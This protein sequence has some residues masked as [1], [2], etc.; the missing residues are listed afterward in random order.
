MYETI[1]PAKHTNDKKS[2]ACG[3]KA[4]DANIQSIPHMQSKISRVQKSMTQYF[5][6]EQVARA[7]FAVMKSEVMEVTV[8]FLIIGAISS[9]FLF[10]HICFNP[11]RCYLL[12]PA[13]L[14]VLIGSLSNLCPPMKNT[15]KS[16]GV[17]AD[18]WT[19]SSAQTRMPF[20]NTSASPSLFL[21]V[22]TL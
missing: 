16:S 8:T 12:L 2:C 3:L 14:A 20:S 6:F 4:S 9:V 1:A 17:L 5:E 21:S 11:R 15:S 13:S 22:V 18:M 10:C 19:S 7:V